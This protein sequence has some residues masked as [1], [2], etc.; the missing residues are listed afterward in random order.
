MKATDTERERDRE[1]EIER[2]RTHT[3]VIEECAD[4]WETACET[5]IHTILIIVAAMQSKSS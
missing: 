5:N 1:R 4:A 2:E 3:N